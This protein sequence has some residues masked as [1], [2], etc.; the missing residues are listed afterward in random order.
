MTTTTGLPRRRTARLAAG[1]L[2]GMLAVTGLA[3][4]SGGSDDTVT[5]NQELDADDDGEVTPAEVMAGAKEHLDET[6]GVEVELST[7]DD[8]GVDYLSAASGTIVAEP[9]AFEGTVDGR[10]SGFDASSINV[11]SVDGTLW[12]E[13]PVIGWTDQYQPAEL[14]APDPA[15]LLDPETGVGNVLTSSEDLEEGD[16]ERGGQDNKEVLTTFSGTAPGD[17]VREV[18]P[19]AEDDSYDVTYRVDGDGRLQSMDM[20]GTFF[21]DSEPVTYVIE[22]TAYDVDKDI[23]APR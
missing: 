17:A 12:V 11:I 18:L 4:C 1:V 9:P 8:P 19:C 16:T 14:C 20:T 2:T 7:G 10:V 5:N 22:V 15:L 3:A 13:A 23:S 21:P 6:S